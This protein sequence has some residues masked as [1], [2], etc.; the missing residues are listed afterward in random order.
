MEESKS[1]DE[2]DKGGRPLKFQ[3]VGELDLATQV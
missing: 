3:T 1:E 2:K